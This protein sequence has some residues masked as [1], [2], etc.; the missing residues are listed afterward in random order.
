MTG[1]QSLLLDLKKNYRGHVT[2][3]DN[4]E[5]KIISIEDIGNHSSPFIE[6]VL[7]VDN[8][9]YNLLS[10]SQFYDKG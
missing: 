2:F 1:D 10:I 5:G 9:K 3:G 6:N 8:L 4:V 7:L